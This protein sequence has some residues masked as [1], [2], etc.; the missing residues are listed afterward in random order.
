MCF[1]HFSIY[2]ITLICLRC[3]H[4]FLRDLADN[5][6]LSFG[7]GPLTLHVLACGSLQVPTKLINCN[8]SQLLA[9]LTWSAS[10]VQELG[11]AVIC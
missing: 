8:A 5:L 2:V 1:L 4:L 3:L 7:P 11:T 6:I 10:A 9:S